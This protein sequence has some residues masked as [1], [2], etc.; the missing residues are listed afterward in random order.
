MASFEGIEYFDISTTEWTLLTHPASLN[1]LMYFMKYFNLN[2]VELD[3]D[4]GRFLFYTPAGE[5]YGLCDLHTLSSS[6]G[7]T[8]KNVRLHQFDETIID[9]RAQVHQSD[10]GFDRM[11]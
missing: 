7:I 3:A 1:D 4:Q 5:R 9:E 11:P 6:T 8:L 10:T 2:T